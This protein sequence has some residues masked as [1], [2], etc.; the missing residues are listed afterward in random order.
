[1]RP[2]GAV[3]INEAV[4]L[5]RDGEGRVAV[6]GHGVP[7]ALYQES[8][9][10]A[11]RAA[12]VQLVEVGLAGP[13][14][15]S[16][17]FEVDRSQV[18]R[19]RRAYTEEGLEG[20]VGKKRGPKGPWKADEGVRRE[21]ER[22][23][24]EGLSYRKIGERVGVSEF[25]VWRCLK[26]GAGLEKEGVA[27]ED[28]SEE[29]GVEPE[30]L[31]A[32]PEPEPRAW[33]RLYA[34]LGRLRE[35]GVEFTVGRALPL[36]GL[37]L[38]VPALV[39]MGYLQTAE[40]VYGG[41]KNGYYGL[42]SVL[43]TLAYLVLL[44]E[45]HPEGLTRVRPRDLGRVLGLDRGP[46]VKT[47]RRKM[48]ELGERE[49]SG[50][51][52]QALA[53]QHIQEHPEALGFAYVDGHVRVYCG[54]E[55]VPKH[56]VARMRLSAPGT[57]DTWVH[58]GG[59]EPVLVWTGVPNA[60]LASELKTAM[61]ELR[62][63]VGPDR[64]VTVIFDRGGWS[65]KLFAG[66]VEEG[67]DF[68]TYRKGDW[69]PLPAGAFQDYEGE[70]EGRKVEY[71]LADT[72]TYLTWKERERGREVERRLHVRQV[73]RRTEEGHQTPIVTSRFDLPALEVAYRM[74]ER[75][76]QE[77]FFRYC[78]EH[79]ALDALHIYEA[80][81]VDPEHKV[82]NPKRREMDHAV[83]AARERV[84]KLENEY[85]QRAMDNEE[86]ERPTMRG[87][88]IANAAVGKE[89]RAARA[90]LEDLLTQ[91]QALPKK[92][93]VAD[94]EEPPVLMSH[95]VKRVMD[96]VKIAAYRAETALLRLLRPAYARAEEEGRSLLRE[97]FQTSGS[98]E[99][100]KGR[101]LITLDPLSAPRRTRAI[102]HV[103]EELTA[104]KVRFPA[105]RLRMCFA[106][107][108]ES[109]DGA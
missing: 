79:F 97:A 104:A 71:E 103:C 85:G 42:R 24:G 29:A 22:L 109:A 58:D 15:V 18:F 14:E 50:E 27:R 17:A 36:V 51:W 78:R 54:K 62:E 89:L 55:N 59:G 41:L 67:F 19:W 6:F 43:L 23:H 93:R 73:V 11:R 83:D 28:A 10:A 35:A 7:L 47:L 53:A 75:W 68:V 106:V 3:A 2:G 13:V 1:V 100:R 92:V 86:A 49:L 39:Q 25:T 61:A 52:M 48:A 21:I 88:K 56:H 5:A 37:M 32:V 84:R 82:S 99:V 102:A 30:E 81:P 74:F 96:V 91:R 70:I 87:F 46:E 45:P 76:R 65:P 105:T 69:S 34:A 26:G 33:D 108:Q 40:K 63:L 80:V 31:A 57:L 16:A 77:N 4:A 64:R 101:L 72:G 9:S 66:M 94:L 44:R 12:M 60:A 107:R 90:E 20:L 8:D 95:E 38:A 98:I